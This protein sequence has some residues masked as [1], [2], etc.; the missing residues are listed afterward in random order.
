MPKRYKINRISENAKTAVLFI[1]GIIGTPAHFKDFVSLVPESFSVCNLLLDGHGKG[2]EDFSKT[3][4]N[5]WKNQVREKVE[6]LKQSH[7][8]IIIAAHS[9]GTLFAINEAFL[10]PDKISCIYLLAAPLKIFLRPQALKNAVK[11]YFNK[12]S[13]QDTIGKATR[14]AY[15]IERDKRFW[16]YLGWIPRY[17]ELFSEIKKTREL[18]PLLKTRVLCFQSENDEMVSM[19]ALEYLKKNENISLEILKNSYHFYYNDED[20]K[21]ILDKFSEVLKND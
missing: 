2:V 8:N 16:K 18:I 6:E 13:P 19:K 11:V 4:M 21:L 7:E 20:Y 1:H 9:M 3:S 15:G 12:I 10:S 14:E 17:L 5:K